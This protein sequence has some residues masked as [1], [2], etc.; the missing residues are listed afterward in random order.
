MPEL[1][2]LVYRA[3]RYRL[4]DD[5][6][7]IREML[8]LLSKGDVALDIGCHKGAYLYWMRSRVGSSGRV[9]AFE[10]QPA[11]A[12]RL[13][14]VIRAAGWKNVTV[15]NIALS[16]SEGAADLHIPG[17]AAAPSPGATLEIREEEPA[18]DSSAVRVKTMRLDSLL[19]A[20]RAEPAVKLIKCDVEG[21]ELDVFRGAEQLLRREGPA[22]LFECEQRHQS[23]RDMREV[24]EFLQALRYEGRFFG[25]GGALRPLAEFDPAAHQRPGARPYCNNFLFRRR[26]SG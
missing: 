8:R 4:R 26:V 18:P 3:W 2:R 20:R 11:L 24:F 10:P 12:A 17:G 9:I 23:G 6:A 13:A 16:S 15:H 22:L 19:P 7:E 21:H 1:L 5:K 25:P 14:R